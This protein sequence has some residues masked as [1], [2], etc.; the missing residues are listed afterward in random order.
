MTEEEKKAKA[1]QM[2]A[3]FERSMMDLGQ[4]LQDY[5][6]RMAQRETALAAA[7]VGIEIRLKALESMNLIK[8][9]NTFKL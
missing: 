5:Q 7:L 2:A 3:L 1:E 6:V 4:A 8:P 9:T